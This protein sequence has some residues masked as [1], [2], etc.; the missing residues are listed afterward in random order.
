MPPNASCARAATASICAGIG[1]VRLDRD[2]LAARRLDR[3]DR[4][5][6]PL[7]LQPG[8]Q[9][10]RTA[11]GEQLPPSRAPIPVAAPVTIAVLPATDMARIVRLCH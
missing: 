5:A 1:D 4:L 11:R 3:R 7:G 6:Q 8:D 9:H 10:A 2:R